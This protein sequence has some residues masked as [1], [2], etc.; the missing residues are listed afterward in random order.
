ME[1]TKIEVHTAR[2][3]K[4]RKDVYG[5][6]GVGGSV[7]DVGTE[8]TKWMSETKATTEQQQ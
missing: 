2:V 4:Q 6:R 3:S 7:Y 8:W 1:E 5:V